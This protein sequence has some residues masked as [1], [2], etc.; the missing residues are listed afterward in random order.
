[1]AFFSSAS[2]MLR[3]WTNPRKKERVKIHRE[4]NLGL[5]LGKTGETPHTIQRRVSEENMRA[6]YS[7]LPLGTR[8][9]ELDVPKIPLP[10]LK[11]EF[12]FKRAKGRYK[13]AAEYALDAV[14]GNRGLQGRLNDIVSMALDKGS[15]YEDLEVQDNT[16]WREIKKA[17]EL[18]GPVRYKLFEYRLKAVLKSLGPY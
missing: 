4:I 15:A 14:N 1:M 16:V 8:M 5:M 6:R 13:L 3:G 18:L 17:R 12:D 11:A 9:F 2:R 10:D 7:K